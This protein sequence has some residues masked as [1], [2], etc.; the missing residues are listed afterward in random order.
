MPF[1]WKIVLLIIILLVVADKLITVANIHAVSKNF[2]DKDPLAI[3][4]NPLAKEFFKQYGL[5]WG[6]MLYGVFSLITFLIALGLLH[7]CLKLFGVSNSLSIA[8]YVV[9]IWYGFVITNNLYF[10]LKFSQIIP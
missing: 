3:E 4:K 10:Y 9:M 1:D 2:P 6:T 5:L 8:L 7:L